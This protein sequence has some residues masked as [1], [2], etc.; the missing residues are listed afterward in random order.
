[1]NGGQ[2]YGTSQAAMT[3]LRHA[4]RVPSKSTACVTIRE[5]AFIRLKLLPS[6][7]HY[8]K[9]P[10]SA[11]TKASLAVSLESGLSAVP[12]TTI[13]CHTGVVSGMT[14]VQVSASIN[15]GLVSGMP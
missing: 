6:C 14:A 8:P 10:M 2:G 13:A 9:D 7:S 11:M 3:G 1:M 12:T 5:F 15:G 4:R